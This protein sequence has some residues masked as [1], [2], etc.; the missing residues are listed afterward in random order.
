MKKVL[1]YDV[2]E[3]KTIKEMLENAGREFEERDA[4]IIKHKEGKKVTYENVTY[5]R[6]LRE[7]NSL[8]TALIDMGYQDKKIAIIGKNRYEWAL[9]FSAIICGV[10]NCSTTRQRASK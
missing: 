3:F 2:K 5:G 8:G 6:L 1:M 9:A 4:F 7:I 10:R